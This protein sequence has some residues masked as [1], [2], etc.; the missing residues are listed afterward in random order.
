MKVEGY[1]ICQPRSPWQEEKW[2]P[3]EWTFGTNT[4]SPWIR[5]TGC[6]YGDDNWDRVIQAWVDRGYCLK[7]ATLEVH[8]DEEGN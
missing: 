1:I 4:V 3:K 6:Q 8:L 2:H 7:K 5:Y